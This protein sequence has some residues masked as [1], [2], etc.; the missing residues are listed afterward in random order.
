MQIFVVP[1]KDLKVVDP[2]TKREIAACGELVESS[3]YWAKRISEGDVIVGEAKKE[4][5]KK[6]QDKQPEF[7][8]FKKESGGK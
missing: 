1:K 4:E 6:E 5:I 3:S 7:K 8:S 2:I